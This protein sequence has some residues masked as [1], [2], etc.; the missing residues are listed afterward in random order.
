MKKYIY[1]FL[2]FNLFFSCNN[3][4]SRNS[5][6]EG[7]VIAEEVEEE[8]NEEDNS[9]DISENP[10]ILLIIA[11]DMGLDATPGYD[12]GQTKPTMPTLQNFIDNGVRFNNLWVNPTCTPTR[13]TILTGKYGFRTGVTNVG[14]EMSTSETSLQTLINSQTSNSYSQAVIGKWHLSSS[15][16]HPTAMGVEHYEGML[17]GTAQA[18]DDWRFTQE[19][20]TTASTDYI[21]TKFTDLA[22][23]WV[24]Q[25]SQPWFL[26]LAYTA[27]HTPFHLPPTDLHSQGSLPSDEASIADNPLPYY[28]AMLESMDTEM[29]RLIDSMTEETLEDT[30]IIFIGDNGTPNQVAQEYRSSRVKGTVY[31]GGINTPMIVTGKNVVRVNEVENALINSTDLFATIADIAGT[32]ITEMHDSIS[33]KNLLTGSGSQ[34]REYAYAE[35]SGDTPEEINYTIRNATHKYILFEDGDEA[36]YDLSTDPTEEVNLMV[37][38]RLPLSVENETIKN[39]LLAELQKIRE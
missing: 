30:V 6:S 34:T 29:G 5:N 10:N 8:V 7:N 16:T 28:L 11:D 1:H 9:D 31:Q 3:D 14:L 22:I 19:E 13:G 15:A 4:D 33:F 24:A 12:F 37:A 32:G 25:Q 27:P 18:Y 36:L 20:T 21:T 17:T 38:A 35:I 23:D 2:I 26:W 39:E